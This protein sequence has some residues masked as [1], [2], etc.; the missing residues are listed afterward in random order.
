M[1]PKNPNLNKNQ[2]NPKSIIFENQ[3]NKSLSKHSLHL[4]KK[5]QIV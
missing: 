5:T 1:N 3:R 4:N 2:R